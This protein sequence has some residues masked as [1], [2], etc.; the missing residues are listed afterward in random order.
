MTEGVDYSFARPGGAA[1]RAAGKS[2]AVRYVPY[3]GDQGK[4]LKAD[5][6]SDLQA[7]GIAV[8]WCSSRQRGGCWTAT[9]PV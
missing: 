5:E 8:G 1:L 9:G 4:G 6:L 2:F 7:N 3:Q